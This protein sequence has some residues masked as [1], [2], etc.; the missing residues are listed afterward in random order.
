MGIPVE[1]DVDVVLGAGDLFDTSA[2]STGEQSLVIR[3]L[4]SLGHDGRHVIVEA[5]NHDKAHSQN[6]TQPW[7]DDDNRRTLT[8]VPC[9]EKPPEAQPVRLER[10]PRVQHPSCTRKRRQHRRWH[11]VSP[12]AKATHHVGHRGSHR[13]VR[14]KSP[15][16]FAERGR[17]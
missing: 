17:L 3:T 14:A 1:E 13:L 5:G 7:R 9:R 6:V 8:R 2:P 11:C 10:T 12:T 15:H 16:A 4:L